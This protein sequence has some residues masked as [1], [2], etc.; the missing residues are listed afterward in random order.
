MSPLV[1]LSPSGEQR[2]VGVGA[3]LEAVCARADMVISELRTLAEA[4]ASR[5]SMRAPLQRR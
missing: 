2:M 5:V 1:G 4:S 3:Q